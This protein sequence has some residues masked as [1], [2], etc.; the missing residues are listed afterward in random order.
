MKKIL[1][2]SGVLLAF[3]A[4]AAL[5]GGVNFAWGGSCWPDN[6]TSNK[7]FACTSNT[8]SGATMTGSFTTTN[9]IP[10]YVGM[11]AV[12]DIQANS[13]SLPAW[14]DFFNTGAC[15]QTSLASS[16]DFTSSN[17]SC[18]DAFA[19]QAGGGTTAYQTST[20]FPA[21]P[22]GLPNAARYKCAWAVTTP[23]DLPAATETD[24]FKATIGGQKT[25]GTGSCAGCL[26]QVTLVLNDVHAAGL[27]G[28]AEDESTPINNGC[29]TWQ[30]TSGVPCNAT[31]VQNK[32]WGSIKS[33]YR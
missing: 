18:N 10:D 20:T 4:S 24:A 21:V 14:W 30:G 16:S 9:E 26:V 11:S 12:V 3:S 28:Q 25:V 17:I 33:L 22:N 31:P 1:L 23:I 27:S 32:T 29:I 13:A 19:G 6:P 15:R 2:L 7:T 5:A 8:L